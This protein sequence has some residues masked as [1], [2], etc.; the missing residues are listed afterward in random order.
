MKNNLFWPVYKQIEKEFKE[1]SYYITIDRKQLKTYSIKI[2]DLILR[3][4]AECENIASVICKNENIKFKDKKGHLRKSVYFNEYIDALNDIFILDKKLVNPIYNNI[5]ENAFDTKLQPFRKEK[6]KINGKE[7][8]IIPW[9]HAYNK[10][11]HDRV[12]NFK[13]ANLENLITALA[14]LFMLNVYLKNEIFYDKDDYDYKKIVSKIEN[15]SDAFQI[16]Y[17]IKTNRYDNLNTNKYSF[18]NPASFWEVALPMSVYVLECD[19]EIK[20]SSDEVSDSMDKLESSI[21]ISKPDGTFEKKCSEY[22]IKDHRTICKIV[23][24]INRC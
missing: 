24:S 17:A 7:K 20:A 8:E 22:N 12:R 16:D 13:Q 3:T 5:D 21:L 1:L 19:K 15:F 23:A 2:A 9:Y 6:I 10:I 4:V 18:F 11:K 14:G